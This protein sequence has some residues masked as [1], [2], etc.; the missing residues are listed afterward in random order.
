M[1]RRVEHLSWL[2]GIVAMLIAF[3]T[4]LP[5]TIIL[6]LISYLV[7]QAIYAM[8][9]WPSEK[10]GMVITEKSRTDIETIGL[11]H[12]VATVLLI[13]IPVLLS[14]LILAINKMPNYITAQCKEVMFD[15]SFQNRNKLNQIEYETTEE[16]K[17]RETYLALNAQKSLL[18]FDMEDVFQVFLSPLNSLLASLSG[19]V[20]LLL[21]VSLMALYLIEQIAFVPQQTNT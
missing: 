13:I 1:S 12:R 19:V 14:M 9:R 20:L 18:M 2:S 5:L 16:A 17:K 4:S 10:P 3:A 21:L 11:F 8:I 7:V 15:T 6:I